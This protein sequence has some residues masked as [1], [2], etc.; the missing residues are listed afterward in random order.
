MALSLDHISSLTTV[1]N[2]SNLYKDQRRLKEVE[3]IN[4]QALIGYKKALGPD[5]TSTL[6]AVNNFGLLYKNPGKLTEAEEMYQGEL[7]DSQKVA[8]PN[9]NRA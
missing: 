4:Q 6:N 8:N 2:L 3:A 1:S 9:A 5:R 7:P